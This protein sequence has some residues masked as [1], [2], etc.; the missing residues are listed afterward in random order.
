MK[1]LLDM[2]GMKHRGTDQFVRALAAGTPVRL[3]REPDNQY[4]GNAIKVCVHDRG[5]D[6][7]VAYV[8]ALQARQLAREMNRFDVREIAA[9]VAAYAEWPAVEV[10]WPPATNQPGGRKSP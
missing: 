9:K 8:K 5:A 7:H 1:L 4:D 6:R 3:V 2:V 10:E